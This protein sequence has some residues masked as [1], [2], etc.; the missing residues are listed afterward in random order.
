MIA[1][2][3]P[4]APWPADP[5]ERLLWYVSTPGVDLWLPTLSE[6]REAAEAAEAARPKMP[7]IYPPTLERTRS[8]QRPVLN[9]PGAKRQGRVTV[10]TEAPPE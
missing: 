9:L 3:I 7:R 1:G 10:T 5:P 4:A 2:R 8:P 6:E